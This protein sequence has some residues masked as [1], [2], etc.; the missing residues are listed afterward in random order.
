MPREIAAG[1]VL[2]LPAWRPYFLE[3]HEVK[4][5]NGGIYRRFRD[6]AFVN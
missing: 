3:F 4:L 1:T 2:G 6:A 5:P